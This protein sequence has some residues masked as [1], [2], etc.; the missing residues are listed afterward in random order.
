MF[1]RYR[2]SGSSAV[3]LSIYLTGVPIPIDMLRGDVVARRILV[4]NGQM[5]GGLWIIPTSVPCIPAATIS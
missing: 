2:D 5:L 1:P 4:F 3:Y